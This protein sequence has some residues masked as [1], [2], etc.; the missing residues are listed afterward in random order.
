M[1]FRSRRSSRNETYELTDDE[2][3][4]FFLKDQLAIDRASYEVQ[5]NADPGLRTAVELAFVQ[6]KQRRG[7]STKTHKVKRD[8]GVEIPLPF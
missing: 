3:F 4:D 5:A 6:W 2:L 1:T 8:E 7:F